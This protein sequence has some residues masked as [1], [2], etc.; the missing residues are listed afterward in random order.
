MTVIEPEMQAERK[1]PFDDK[2]QKIWKGIKG[3]ILGH[4]LFSHDVKFGLQSGDDCHATI[5]GSV[6]SI[7]IKILM[8]TYIRVIIS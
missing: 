1:N 8:I 2:R 5:T 3:F 6:F 4:D 7:I